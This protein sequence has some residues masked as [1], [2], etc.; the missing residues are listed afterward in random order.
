MTQLNEV[1]CNKTDIKRIFNMSAVS[2]HETGAKQSRIL[3][4]GLPSDIKLA[5]T[6]LQSAIK[7]LNSKR[8]ANVQHRMVSTMEKHIKQIMQ[9]CRVEIKTA[10]SAGSQ[11]KYNI[12]GYK[13]CVQEAVTAIYQILATTT[14]PP[15]LNQ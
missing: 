9:D 10:S 3:I 5:E 13:E 6:K 2:C 1:T 12:T 14:N 11:A 7:L 15:V 4:F 8:S